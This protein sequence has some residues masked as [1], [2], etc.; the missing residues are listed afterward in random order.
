MVQSRDDYLE[1]YEM[2]KDIADPVERQR[3]MKNERNRR[4][5]KANRDKVRAA[6]KRYAIKYPEKVKQESMVFRQ[7]HPEYAKKW[8][9][10]H[11][12]E[13]KEWWQNRSEEQKAA[14][15]EYNKNWKNKQ[16]TEN[17]IYRLRIIISTSMMRSIK[18]NKTNKRLYRYLG[19]SIEELKEHLEH[20]F[21]DWMNWDNLGLTANKEKETWQIDHIIPVNT[22][23]IKEIGDEEFRK[24]WA[25]DNLRPLDSY[26]NNRRPKDG[27]DIKGIE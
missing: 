26:I 16:Y 11:K 6:R 21:E 9:T 4:W 20:Q 7:E 3:L 19:Y 1:I 10:K 8:Y 23:N 5:K 27:S 18:K 12:E 14:K 25:L 2:Y 15:A 17:T 24:C 13:A 22:F